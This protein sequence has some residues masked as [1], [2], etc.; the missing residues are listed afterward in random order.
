MK[1][2]RSSK[3]LYGLL[4][5]QWRN[6]RSDW[7]RRRHPRVEQ[8]QTGLR[9]IYILPTRNGLM[10][11]LFL[12]FI[13]LLAVNY[14]NALIYALC[15]WL[16]ALAVLNLNYTHYNLS[17][18]TLRC[19]AGRN[20]VAGETVEFDVQVSRDKARGRHAIMLAVEGA[21]LTHRVDLDEATSQTVTFSV[22]VSTRGYQLLPRITLHSDYPLG[23]AR[24]WSYAQLAACALVYPRPVDA[25]LPA[26]RGDLPE[27]GETTEHVPGVSDF[28]A[29]RTYVP[30][31]RLSRVHWAAS[32]RSSVLQVKQF[33][34]PLAQS[35][36]LRWQD[37]NMLPTEARL[38]HLMFTI[39]QFDVAR[40]SYGLELPEVRLQPAMGR[41]HYHRCCEA[42][43]RFGLTEPDFD[44]R[45]R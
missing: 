14:Q 35:E 6:R 11:L 43:A 13:F 2:P 15:F 12:G 7:I 32:S 28:E 16:I 22:P 3:G 25:M 10:L 9:S 40:R 33:V 29:L 39:N 20:G 36:W 1:N 37:F 42:L 45:Q 31:D 27:A 26:Q 4:S 5:G 23:I 19:V 18:I 34:D 38:Q 8:S 41:G 21:E 30:G 17:G 44:G 24:A